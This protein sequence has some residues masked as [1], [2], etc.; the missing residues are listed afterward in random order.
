[1]VQ[2]G[3]SS[4]R[5]RQLPVLLL[6]QSFICKHCFRK[7]PVSADVVVSNQQRIKTRMVQ[8]IVVPLVDNVIPPFTCYAASCNAQQCDSVDIH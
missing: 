3:R 4:L 6:D 7:Q 5:E 8:P 2:V 1:M